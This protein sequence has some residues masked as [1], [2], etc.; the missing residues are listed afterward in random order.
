MPDKLDKSAR[1]KALDEAK[2]NV[3]TAHANLAE[4]EQRFLDA[5]AGYATSIMA[6]EKAHEEAFAEEHEAAARD[7]KENDK[8]HRAHCEKHCKDIEQRK[9]AREAKGE[10]ELRPHDVKVVAID[11]AIHQ[12]IAAH[13]L[14][15]GACGFHTASKP[16]PGSRFLVACG[17]SVDA[18]HDELDHE[19]FD[20]AAATCPRCQGALAKMA[21][22]EIP[23]RR[24]DYLS[25]KEQ[26]AHARA[27]NERRKKTSTE[28]PR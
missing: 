14:M 19:R 24:G 25:S 3:E 22:G 12:V 6:A 28:R 1:I 4:L 7:A 15:L 2:A 9:K 18:P 26:I 8:R 20:Q 13:E 10:H 27:E 17:Y 21:A 5:K 23:D 11:G 16:R